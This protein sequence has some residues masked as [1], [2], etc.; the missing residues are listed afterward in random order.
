MPKFFS[1]P[2]SSWHFVVAVCGIS[3]IFLWPTWVSLHEF[4]LAST[5]FTHGH[6]ILVIFAYLVFVQRDVLRRLPPRPFFPALVLLAALLAVWLVA[7]LAS[8]QAI[9]QLVLP[10]IIWTMLLV[11]AG[12]KVA[13]GLW[14]QV[15]YLYL[16]VPI[17][18]SGNYVLQL[19]TVKAVAVGL[20]L[21]QVSAY[22]EGTMVN[23]PAGAFEVEARCSGLHYLIVAIALSV[24]YSLLYLKTVRSR[25]LVIA[26]AIGM[27]LLTNWLRVFT[28]VYAG[29]L[30]DMQHFLVTHDHYYFGWVLFAV[31]LIPY[32]KFARGLE[33][34]EMS[35]RS[36]APKPSEDVSPGPAARPVAALSAC[37]LA[38]LASSGVVLANAFVATDD[39]VRILM[40]TAQGAWRIGDSDPPGWRP[41]YVGA[42]AEATKNYV[43]SEGAVYAYR[44]LYQGQTQGQELIGYHN[45]IEGSDAWSIESQKIRQVE[46]SNATNFWFVRE[47][48]LAATNGEERMLYL[49]YDVGGK[50]TASDLEAKIIYGI[51][52]LLGRYDAGVNI[53]SAACE[54]N[55]DGARVL[56]QEW[57]DTHVTVNGEI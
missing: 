13:K 39:D 6:L 1:A 27:A 43:S 45:R 53:V 46:L 7:V 54:R 28:V 20:W 14:A 30:T 9:H 23:L 31:M 18:E 36:N 26:A 42:A 22:V 2:L 3:V 38:L 48:Y 51:N 55:C 44:N 11:V 17:W 33:G 24:L 35:D 25:F 32:L 34:S 41:H 49:W 56:L 16:A 21:F 5:R 57:M 4:W 37:A 47:I 29:H 12:W 40:P 15:A 8:I 50:Q 19:L 52:V 10:A